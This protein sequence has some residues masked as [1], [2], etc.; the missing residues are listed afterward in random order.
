MRPRRSRPSPSR[1]PL[2]W[3]RVRPIACRPPLPSTAARRRRCPSPSSTAGSTGL[4]GR[5]SPASSGSP[6]RCG[7]SRCSS[8]G[9]C[10]IDL[11]D[12]ATP[13]TAAAPP[14]GG[15]LVEPVG[16]VARQP[17]PAGHHPRRRHGGPGQG[18]GPALQAR[19]DIGFIL[20]E[21]DTDALLGQG[22][23][24]TGPADQ[25]AGGRGPLRR[26]PAAGRSPPVPSRVGL[27]ASPGT[28]GFRDFLGRLRG[29][30]HGLRRPVVPTQVQ[31]RR[32][33]GIGGRRPSAGS[34]ASAAT[35]SS[36]SAAAVPR[37]TWPP[38]TPSR[39]PGPSP[40]SACRCG[41]ASATPATSRWPTRWPTGRSSPRP[42]AARSWP[43]RRPTSGGPAGGRAASSGG[44][45]GERMAPAE[46]T[47]DRHRHGMVTGARSQL[48]RHAD[49][50][51]HRSYALRAAA[52][53]PARR[54]RSP[55]DQRVEELAKSSRRSVDAAAGADGRPRPGGWLCC[56][57]RRLRGGGPRG[58]AT[59]GGCSAPTTTIA[60]SSAATR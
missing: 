20:S 52:Q 47:L 17:R 55:V 4:C 45:P 59:G 49:R 53:G 6:G 28:E 38:S 7:R 57:A 16:R 1:G 33:P 12:P 13:T 26:Q 50:L 23:G 14:Q 22:G 40:A 11:V 41:P 24:R 8:R 54:P 60:S 5:R 27:V 32:G 10:Y 36:S 3:P 43:G 44:W 46:R 31:G 9:H 30:G 18:R 42:S 39:W 2:T 56:P 35:S 29:V 19:G 21:L 34:S 51:V 58:S 48:D 25:G 15:V 37:P